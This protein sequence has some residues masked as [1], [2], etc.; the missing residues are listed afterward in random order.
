M[1]VVDY[2]NKINDSFEAYLLFLNNSIKEN[3]WFVNNQHFLPQLCSPINIDVFDDNLFLIKLENNFN[4]MVLDSLQKVLPSNI[5]EEYLPKINILLGT[6]PNKTSN[7]ISLNGTEYTKYTSTQMKELLNKIHGL[8]C[9]ENM[10]NNITIKLINEIYHKDFIGL[11][12][13]QL[14]I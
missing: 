7:S 9:V 14:M 12:Y 13:E 10:L 11:G 4:E 3:R 6:T 8:P 2:I 5:Y 1:L